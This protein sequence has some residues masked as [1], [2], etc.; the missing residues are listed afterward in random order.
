MWFGIAD[1]RFDPPIALSEI[2]KAINRVKKLPLIPV[3]HQFTFTLSFDSDAPYFIILTK[4]YQKIKDKLQESE[5]Y[6][7]K[8]TISKQYE[9]V[10][11]NIKYFYQYQ[12][13]RAG[14]KIRE[15]YKRKKGIH[16]FPDRILITL[17]PSFNTQGF[18]IQGYIGQFK[19]TFVIRP[20]KG[21]SNVNFEDVLK[22]AKFF[23]VSMGIDLDRAKEELSL[24]ENYV[25][26]D[27]K[28]LDYLYEAL[29]KFASA[30]SLI[31]NRH[32]KFTQ[33]FDYVD[34]QKVITLS[35]AI[36]PQ[37]KNFPRIDLKVY[38]PEDYF[39][40]DITD[41][42][43]HPKVESK[44]NI[45]K[46]ERS[47]YKKY[48]EFNRAFLLYFLVQSRIT[49]DMLIP[50]TDNYSMPHSYFLNDEEAQIWD[51]YVLN[52]VKVKS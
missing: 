12:Y 47:D 42:G 50:L 19:S 17:Y 10:L 11:Q 5:D 44:I 22:A 18:S 39:D 45:P 1:F 48:L 24:S 35:R 40:L 29:E 26:V 30:F 14:A 8:K 7:Y 41:V 3:Q 23:F 4:I 15:F 52:L 27:Q 21:T 28:Y 36:F 20:K 13:T 6:K 46:Q 51:E 31:L 32:I 34:G 37:V 2:L 33:L 25:R 38:L 16:N 9:F 43:I 49:S